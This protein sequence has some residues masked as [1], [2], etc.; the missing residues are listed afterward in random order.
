MISS[1]APFG[2]FLRTSRFPFTR[3]LLFGPPAEKRRKKSATWPT[4]SRTGS[5]ST[6]YSNRIR[7]KL[8]PPAT[9]I[10][11]EL[12]SDFVVVFGLLQRCRYGRHQLPDPEGN[13]ID[14]SK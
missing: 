13:L 14:V 11:L 10:N 5:A 12:I 4:S 2:K 3:F 1:L 8:M 9:G 6:P 7:F